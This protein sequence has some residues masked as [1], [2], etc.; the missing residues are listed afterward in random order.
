MKDDLQILFYS[1]FAVIGVTKFILLL[2]N[3]TGARQW[4][5]ERSPNAYYEKL[6]S[7]DF[8]LSFRIS[9]ILTFALNLGYGF[10]MISLIIPL[11]VS[12]LI[13][14]TSN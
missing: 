8:C 11:I 13:Q 4:L 3:M 2:G 6:F 14:T 5:I 7:C 1:V 10:E 9:V 12:G